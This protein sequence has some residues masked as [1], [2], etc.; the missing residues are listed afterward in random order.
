MKRMAALVLKKRVS[1]L[2]KIGAVELITQVD[3][4]QKLQ[5]SSS[6]WHMIDMLCL[7]SWQ[8]SLKEL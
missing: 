8:S 1:L 6:K 5:L 3:L 7:L 2:P 4:K